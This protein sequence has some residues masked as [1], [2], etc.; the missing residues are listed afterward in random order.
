MLMRERQKCRVPSGL[1]VSC[2][3]IVLTH[4]HTHCHGGHSGGCVAPTGSRL[5]AEHRSDI[6]DDGGKGRRLIAATGCRHV[7]RAPQ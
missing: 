4:P 5:Q 3:A 6:P 2:A 7:G 1:A